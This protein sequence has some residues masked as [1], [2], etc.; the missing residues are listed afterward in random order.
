MTLVYHTGQL[1]RPLLMQAK[2]A[3]KRVIY[4]DGEDERVLR[5]AQ[6]VVDEQI[7]NP[8]LIGRPSAIQMRLKK[9]GLRLVVGKDIDIVDPEDDARFNETWSASYKLQ[10]RDGVQPEIAKAMVSSDARRG[11][12]ECVSTCRARR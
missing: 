10:G 12:K 3:P 5:A 2:S 6:T 7:A 9:F 1:M 4:A 11:G 8:I